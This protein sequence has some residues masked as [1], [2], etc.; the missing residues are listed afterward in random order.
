MRRLAKLFTF[1]RAAGSSLL[2]ALLLVTLALASTAK[3]ASAATFVV[4]NTSDA[5]DASPGDGFC[6]DGNG[7]CTLRAAVMEANALAGAD[8][9][10]LPAGTYTLSLGPGDDDA[11]DGAVD[12]SGDLDILN[13]DLTLNGAGA[14]TT[15]IQAGTTNANGIDRVFDVDPPFGGLGLSFTLSGVTVRN[16]QAPAPQGAG[17][18]GAGI[19]Y[20]GYSATTPGTLTLANC[21]LQDNTAQA[22]LAGGVEVTGGALTMS[23]TTVQSNT[24]TAGAGGGV[25]FDDQGTNESLAIT[26]GGISSNHAPD[27]SFGNGGGLYIVS[28]S[29]AS[30][31]SVSFSS[32]SA[33]LDGGGIYQA[34][35]SL[36]LNAVTLSSNTAGGNGSGVLAQSTVSQAGPITLT[37]N[38]YYQDSGV[39]NG[40]ASSFAVDGVLTLAGGTFIAPS[41]TTNLGGDFIVGPGV[42]FS[43]NNGTFLF[44]GL[45][46]QNLSLSSNVA[47]Y[48]LTVDNGVI[49]VETAP[50]DYAS[51]SHTLTNNGTIRKAQAISGAGSKTFG[52]TGVAVNVTAQASL[53]NLSVDRIDS[54]PLN[55]TG[56]SAG[57]TNTGRYWLL[58]PTGAGFSLNL[59]LPHSYPLNDAQTQ[60]CEWVAGPGFGWDCART[61]STVTTVTRNGITSLS[62]WAVGYQVSPTS[63]TLRDFEAGTSGTVVGVGILA[64]LVALFLLAL[65]RRKKIEENRE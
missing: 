61:S 6:D 40:G 26:G 35:G 11:V 64:T 52:L 9:I 18:D 7:R 50:T 55:G 25:Y 41:G 51:V 3:P 8:T 10:T 38:D 58:T 2:V 14:G 46:S 27:A 56:T 48:D 42:T 59:T 32:N 22:G 62:E 16:G 19:R 54:D 20:F 63:I 36:S 53:T 57:G 45:P 29:S 47:F 21:I 31:S 4:D 24:A 44:S 39:F 60:V 15:I 5:K 28:S 43:A 33:A 12:S 1:L 34:L 23:N 49:L 13:D 65:L 17:G 30:L 37:N